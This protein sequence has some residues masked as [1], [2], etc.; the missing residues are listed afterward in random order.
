MHLYK[1]QQM[2]ELADLLTTFQ[3]D[4]LRYAILMGY[5]NISL[6]KAEYAY[7]FFDKALKIELIING[8]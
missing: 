4:D 5:T 8:H 2:T 7:P 6:G 1:H 3:S